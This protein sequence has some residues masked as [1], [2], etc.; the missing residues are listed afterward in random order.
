M[1]KNITKLNEALIVRAREL[2]I[3]C[4]KV[5]L[6][7]SGGIDS[8][9]VAGILCRAF[10]SGNVVGLYRDIR[11]NPQHYE[12]VKLLQEVLGFKLIQLDLNSIYDS[13]LADLKKQ[14][15][16]SGLP[17][18][19]D[20]DVA[21]KNG[22]MNA[23][24][25]FKS[26]L[27]TP[28]AGFISKAI[29]GGHGRIFGTGN[30][31]EDGLLRYFDKFGDGAVDNN[32]INGLNKAEVRQLARY[33]GIPERIILKKPSADLE[34][35]GNQ[36]NDEDQLSSSARAMGYDIKISYGEADGSQEGNV[37]WAWR[38]D[39]N[40]GVVTGENCNL[41][42]KDLTQGPY[43]YSKEQIK[44]I[45]FLRQVEKATRHKIEP[46]PGLERKILVQEG[47]VD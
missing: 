22:L 21:M 43:D 7:V 36:H 18:T 5:F 31:E 15:L 1:I 40:H 46:I 30:G 38:E 34:G 28:L 44:V 9:T 47:L 20:G 6:S 8:A 41:T 42:E 37:A 4:E 16:V 27:T 2:A 11:S 39:I 17:W 35:N 29:D 25:S 12:D 32:I 19:E 10:G 3:G 26:R 24:A 23:Y 14:F 45:Y 33:L 13:L